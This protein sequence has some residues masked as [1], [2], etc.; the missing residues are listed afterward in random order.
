MVTSAT[1]Q[2]LSVK[3][4]AGACLFHLPDPV[5][6][7]SGA[8]YS[9]HQKFMLESQTASLCVLDWYTCGRMTR[10]EEW[11]F[12]RYNSVNEVWCDKKRLARDTLLL[13]EPLALGKR[14]FAHRTLKERL[15]PYSCYATV[16]LFGP[17]TAETVSAL[18][19]SLSTIVQYKQSKPASFIWS[20][21]P[22]DDGGILRAA[23]TETETIKDWLKQTLKTFIPVI[24]S[25]AYD[26]AFV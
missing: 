1:M 26:K 20:F 24:G 7:F 22:M 5:T 25:E 11:A 3:V 10:G 13:E 14:P 9:Q 6:C 23:A 2:N 8:I 18:H 21:S 15:A 19:S 17:A 12:E 16:L 4:A